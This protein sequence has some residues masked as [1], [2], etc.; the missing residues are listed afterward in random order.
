MSFLKLGE[1]LREQV[2]IFIENVRRIEGI[3]KIINLTAEKFLNVSK[4]S[5]FE[6]YLAEFFSSNLTLVNSTG[7]IE[8]PRF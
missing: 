8:F 4:N 3:E 5:E 7:S 6:S 2:S 1:D